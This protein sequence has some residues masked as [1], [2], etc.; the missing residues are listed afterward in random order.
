MTN[1]FVVD[2]SLIV[3]LLGE[4]WLSD[5][6]AL[7]ASANSLSRTCFNTTV[8]DKLIQ[9]RTRH[10]KHLRQLIKHVR[11]LDQQAD[12]KFAAWQKAPSKRQRVRLFNQFKR[13]DRKLQAAFPRFCYQPKVLNEML[14]VTE[15][16]RDKFQAELRT[17]ENLE[18]QRKSA[19]RQAPGRLRS[20]T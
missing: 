2:R 13:F 15:N 14:L 6:R 8:I 20:R 18:A 1:S 9:S 16:I 17:I 4:G 7:A 5:Y 12:A 10:I 3:L 19:A 11:A